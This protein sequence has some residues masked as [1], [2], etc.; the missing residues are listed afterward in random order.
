MQLKNMIERKNERITR[1]EEI[2][3]GAETEK[4][5]LTDEEAAGAT[6]DFASASPFAQSD[7]P[8]WLAPSLERAFG[9]DWIAE[10]QAMAGRPSLDLRV[11]ALKAT[12]EK[13]SSGALMA[14]GTAPNTTAAAMPKPIRQPSA[15]DAT[16]ILIETQ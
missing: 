7:F 5:E 12:P 14:F 11:N 4:R 8:E 10:G 3:K 13:V 9:A 2:L 16:E 15:A 6:A 1:A